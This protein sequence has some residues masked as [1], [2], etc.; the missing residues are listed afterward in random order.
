[1]Q[2]NGMDDC[3]QNFQ[4]QSNEHKK[5]G[6]KYTVPVIT[7]KIPHIVL[8]I[9]S[10]FLMTMAI[11]YTDS[12]NGKGFMLVLWCVY[13]IHN[14]TVVQL[15]D[16]KLPNNKNVAF[17]YYVLRYFPIFSGIWL[18]Q[19]VPQISS[20]CSLRLD[21]KNKNDVVI[22]NLFNHKIISFSRKCYLLSLVNIALP[23]SILVDEL[24]FI[25]KKPYD[26]IACI[27]IYA[28]FSG[29]TFY[30]FYTFTK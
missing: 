10:V 13:I 26:V 17:N 23:I 20:L 18:F 11:M 15:F 14:G 6:N 4:D 9:L 12:E 1:M 8:F 5:D 21:E 27:V 30:S 24:G 3:P 16:K 25:T 28:I 22:E 7:S 2:Q 19:A 29:N